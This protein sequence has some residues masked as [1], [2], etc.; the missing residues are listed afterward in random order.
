VVVGEYAVGMAEVLPVELR[1]NGV[2]DFGRTH[3][4]GY[5]GIWGAGAIEDGHAV[6]LETA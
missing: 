2:V 4:L 6:V 5:Y 3:A 1:D